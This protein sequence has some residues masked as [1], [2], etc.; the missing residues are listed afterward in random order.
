[1]VLRRAAELSAR[2]RGSD[3]A[4]SISPEV[5]VQVAGALGIAEQDV[6]RALFD[7]VSERTAEPYTLSRRLYGPSRLRAVRE[8]PH[9]P[10]ETREHLED[11]L[12]HEHG[13][14]L[15]QKT[16][17]SSLF[18]AGD[19]LG[20]VRRALDFTGNRALLKARSLEL[21]VEDAGREGSGA[22]LTTDVVNQRAEY[23][24]FSGLLGATLALP[25]ALAGFYEWPYF[26]AVPPALVGPY[27]GFRLA[28]RKTCADLRRSMDGLLDAAEEGAPQKK[29]PEQEKPRERPPGQIR[30]L[31]PIPR[32]SFRPPE[33]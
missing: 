1:M 32:F 27:Y 13:L 22:S 18:D 3:D 4:G 19:L 30:Q 29:E 5:L 15:R 9:P 21:R 28:Y 12:R 33:E 11:L 16:E 23:L 6:R 17:A 20:A 14:K 8:I 2:R 7:L 26:L 25:L 24:S 10:E 31:R